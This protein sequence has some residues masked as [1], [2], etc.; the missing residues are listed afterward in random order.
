MHRMTSLSVVVMLAVMAFAPFVRVGRTAEPSPGVSTVVAEGSGLSADE[1]LKDALRNAVSQVVGTYL[2]ANTLVEND[3]LISDRVLTYSNGFIRSYRVVDESHRNGLI[4]RKI[5][6]VV[7]REPLL[8]RLRETKLV[9]QEI[10]GRSLVAETLIRREAEQSATELL[11]RTFDGFP[12]NVVQATVDERPKMIDESNDRVRLVFRVHISVDPERFVTFQKR[13]VGV[14]GQIATCKGS[15]SAESINVPR[16]HDVFGNEFFSNEFLGVSRRNGTDVTSATFSH[17]QS[18]RSTKVSGLSADRLKSLDEGRTSLLFVVHSASDSPGLHTS[19]K[20]FETPLSLNLPGQALRVEMS[21][22]DRDGHEVQRDSFPL[23]SRAPALS[24]DNE[25]SRDGMP[26]KVIISPYLLFHSG[27]GFRAN[28]VTYTQEMIIE[29][30]SLFALSDLS[31]VR[32]VRC[33]VTTAD[34]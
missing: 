24:V 19:W 27:L 26:R 18:F 2:D 9:G 31:D 3:R 5:S 30:E 33:R 28:V 4:R 8:R 14:L 21:H 15:M 1:A 6:A 20:W 10:D 17:F 29:R 22:I 12:A 23:G 7:E 25:P 32:T 11:K 16:Q 13:L 34:R